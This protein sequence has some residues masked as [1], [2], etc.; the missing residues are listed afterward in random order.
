[1]TGVRKF[2]KCNR[3]SK[4]FTHKNDFRKHVSRKN[5]CKIVTE[6]HPLSESDRFKCPKCDKAYSSKSNLTRH[7]KGF[8][9]VEPISQ[10]DDDLIDI[11]DNNGISDVSKSDKPV[12]HS[13]ESNN[14]RIDSQNI[15]SFCKK[16]FTRKDNLLRHRANGCN[17]KLTVH[18]QKEL[19]HL[20]NEMQNLKDEIIKLKHIQQ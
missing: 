7:I 5:R 2:Y 15:C 9:N 19:E 14:K 8:C 1:M 13:D 11:S 16:S 17:I 10:V 18:Q 20:I 3:C 12:S 6:E 4:I